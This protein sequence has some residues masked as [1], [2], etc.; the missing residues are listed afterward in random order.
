MSQGRKKQQQ[1]NNNQQARKNT[2]E[3]EYREALKHYRRRRGLK[4]CFAFFLV[5]VLAL[6][7]A[8]FFGVREGLNY[9][10]HNDVTKLQ[11]AGYPVGQLL[12]DH[13][14]DPYVHNKRP[15][16]HVYKPQGSCTN[17]TNAP[18]DLIILVE[19]V[20]AQPDIAY[21][22]R[23]LTSFIS[24]LI[25]SLPPI[26]PSTMN[27][28]IIEFSTA[29][30]LVLPFNA[31]T[32]T[33]HVLSLLPSALHGQTGARS[34]HVALRHA[35]S[36]LK[37]HRM[38]NGN[39]LVLII[40]EGNPVHRGVQ[41]YTSFVSKEVL[42]QKEKS[43][44]MAIPRLMMTDWVTRLNWLGVGIRLVNFGRTFNPDDETLTGLLGD[45]FANKLV[46]AKLGLETRWI[47]NHER[48]I[49]EKTAEMVCSAAMQK[50]SKRRTGGGTCLNEES[51]KWYN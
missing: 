22:S 35:Y 17:L 49:V 21:R 13:V 42:T 26:S 5:L 41:D 45:G 1:N 25:S 16:T 33:S 32:S 27:V 30:S 9:I 2:E 29:S 7:I 19:N 8:S 34:I 12:Q 43:S 28:A 47:D 37:G 11:V 40:G 38:D 50:E 24:S 10:D 18:F 23:A 14:V 46:N 6:P 39:K 4:L 51:R 15:S 48:E 44:L 31:S 3:E 20:L 36:A